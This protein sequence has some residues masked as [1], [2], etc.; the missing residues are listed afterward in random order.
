M[1]F[2]SCG[3]RD[4]ET[5]T[6]KQRI[7]FRFELDSVG[8][9]T[10]AEVKKQLVELAVQI[11]SHAD[12]VIMYSY[13]EK[14]KTMEES[15]EIATQQAYAAKMLMYKSAVERI[16]YSVGVEAKGFENPLDV[17]HPDSRINRRIEFEYL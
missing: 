3:T 6:N 12:K 2:V 15:I 8:N 14:M 9:I 11:S 7:V 1:L 10:D 16:Y 17:A 5:K 13:T 4:K